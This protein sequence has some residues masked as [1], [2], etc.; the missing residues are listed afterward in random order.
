[1]TRNEAHCRDHYP[2]GRGLSFPEPP[3]A[4]AIAEEKF[5][6]VTNGR[7]VKLRRGCDDDETA[8]WAVDVWANAPGDDSGEVGEYESGYYFGDDYAG[9]LKNYEACVKL[10][11]AGLPTDLPGREMPS[12]LLSSLI[13]YARGLLPAFKESDG[14]DDW[15]L[16]NEDWHVNLYRVDGVWKTAAY[17]IDNATGQT[18]GSRWLPLTAEP[19]DEKPT[20]ENNN[21]GGTE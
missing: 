2:R 5:S 6:G 10:V 15:Y 13:E 8:G 3:R 20:N 17:P 1:M 19:A 9:A 11:E 7:E 21:Q 14:E 18:D 4:E 16:F 12:G